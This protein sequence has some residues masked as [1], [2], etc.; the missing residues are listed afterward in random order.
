MQA[1]K[2]ELTR[3]INIVFMVLMEVLLGR[4]AIGCICKQSSR[5]KQAKV[6]GAEPWAR[7]LRRRREGEAE[8]KKDVEEM[9]TE[10]RQIE[11]KSIKT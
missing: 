10:K 4:R 3:K 8:T 7:P 1:S 9:E 5:E 11:G 6:A 2:H